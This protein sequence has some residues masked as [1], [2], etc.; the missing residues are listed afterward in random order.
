MTE[1]LN[2]AGAWIDQLWS[3]MGSISEPVAQVRDWILLTFGQNGLYAAY[4]V[5]AGLGIMAMIALVR[6]AIATLKYLVLPSVALAAIG[7]M[8]FPVSFTTLLP[9][10]VTA[11]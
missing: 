3:G 1:L 2:T 7:A 4:V 9:V 8:L 11:C 6:M 5:A 10:T